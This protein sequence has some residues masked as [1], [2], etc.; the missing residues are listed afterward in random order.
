MRAVPL[1][2]LLAAAMSACSETPEQTPSVT[3][4]ASDQARPSKPDQGSTACEVLTNESAAKALGRDVE[5][6]DSSGGPSGLDICQYGYQGER[7]ADMGNVSVTVHPVDLAS[8]IEGAT[9]QGYKLEPVAGLGDAAWYSAD[10]GLYVGKGQRTAH[11]LLAANGMEDPKGK[12]IALA[13]DTIGR[14]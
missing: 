10:V 14:L 3:D 11:Y 12:I 9:A 2:C 6:L 4:Q 5:K 13:N 8:V 1:L 7:L